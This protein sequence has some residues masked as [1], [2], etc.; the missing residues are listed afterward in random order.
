MKNPLLKCLLLL[1]N[2]TLATAMAAVTVIVNQN[3][4]EFDN[5]PRLVEVLAPFAN[6]QNW[7]WPSAVLFQADNIDL[8]KTRQMLLN[9]LSVVSQH[10]RSENPNLVQSLEQLRAS[11]SNWRLARRLPVKIDYDLARIAAS[12]NPQ[13]S[14]GKY[15]LAL[16]ERKNTVQLFGAINKSSQITHLGHSDVSHYISDQDRTNLAN[17]DY[18]IL[19][20]A[21]GRKIEV[22]VAYWNKTHQEVMPGSQIFVPFNESLF[23]PEFKLINQQI[24]TLAQNRL[25]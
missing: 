16:S 20:Q 18:A 19:I 6:E 5:E 21:D 10:Y 2:F 24:A 22:P 12:A 1:S 25:Q 13:L 9:N 3:N 23:R 17:E 7:Y 4:Y 8:E 15:V 14:H 11:I